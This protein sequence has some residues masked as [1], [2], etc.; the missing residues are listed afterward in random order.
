M[1]VCCEGGEEEEGE[2]EEEEEDRIEVGGNIT[3]S[4][5]SVKFSWTPEVIV[6]DSPIHLSL[7]T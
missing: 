4:I 5:T 3:G 1:Y 2:G 7:N 6:T